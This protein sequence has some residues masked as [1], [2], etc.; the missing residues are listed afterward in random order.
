MKLSTFCRIMKASYLNAE[1]IEK[2][3]PTPDCPFSVKFY[4]S[5]WLCNHANNVSYRLQARTQNMKLIDEYA[6]LTILVH[7]FIKSA[8]G[9]HATAD[10]YIR[11]KYDMHGPVDSLVLEFRKCLLNDMI[12]WAKS[13]EQSHQQ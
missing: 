4:E 2:R 12:E 3:Y 1:Y 8:I 9:S 7:T 6:E 10:A 5:V 11:D 13:Q